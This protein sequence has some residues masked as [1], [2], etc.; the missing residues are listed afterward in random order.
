[1]VDLR[2]GDWRDVLADVGEVDA[3]ITDPP[4]GARTHAGHDAGME[5][6]ADGY[7]GPNRNRSYGK[8]RRRKL[9]YSSWTPT[10][11][12]AFVD[13]WSPRVR[14]WFCAISCSDLFPVWREALHDAGRCTFA[15]VACVIRAMSVRI[16]GDGPSSW[17]V[18]LNVARP[19]NQEFV[20]WGALNGAYVVGR[21]MDRGSG[22][23][24]GK[25]LALMNAIVRDY[26]RPGDLI[27]D[28]CAGYATTAVAAGE[29]GRRFVG[30]E[31][32]AETH[33]KAMERLSRPQQVGLFA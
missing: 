6:A 21:G 5:G 22:H 8:S 16:A 20:K 18:Y 15:P 24:G 29:Y 31:V 26:T 19:R 2:L 10:D 23:I 25:P 27:C 11:V 3:L 4:Y 13:H 32:D 28:P 9:D 30:A 1:M 14:G 12:R 17:T 7:T 33:A